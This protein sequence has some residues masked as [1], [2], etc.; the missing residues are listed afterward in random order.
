MQKH[1]KKLS[2]TASGTE[3]E[4][5]L[6]QHY[7]GLGYRVTR[8]QLLSGHQ[9][10]LMASKDVPGAGVVNVM[11]EAK[12]R[13]KGA[14]GINDI[15]NSLNAAQR[16][17]SSHT[18][19][20]AAIIANVAFTAEAQ[21]AVR[22]SA[23]IQLLTLHDLQ[24]QLFNSSESLIRS[25]QDYSI[26][27]VSA[28]YISLA[29]KSSSGKRLADIA[30]HLHYNCAHGGSLLVLLGDFGSGK[31]TILE[32]VFIK[33]AND[34]LHDPSA[35]FP[36]FLRLR[37]LRQHVELWPFIAANLRDY[38]YITPPKQV[39]DSQLE[40]GRLA[41]FL[42]GF[43]EI[44]AG[45]S[46]AD[47]GEFLARLYPLMNSSSPCILSSRPTYFSSPQDML[48]ALSV[49][50]GR[51]RIVDGTPNDTKTRVAL[52]KLRKSMGLGGARHVIANLF[53]D[54]WTI[55][56]LSEEAILAY[57]KQQETTLRSVT[58]KTAIEIR[59]ALGRVYD[60]SDLMRRPLL[61][62]MIVET[63]LNDLIDINKQDM[64]IGPSSL[65][66]AYTQLS[67]DRDSEK[68][69]ERS[70][71]ADARRIVCQFLSLA[72]AK[73]GSAELSDAEVRQ[74]IIDSGIGTGHASP[75]KYPVGIVGRTPNQKPPTESAIEGILTD[76]RSGSFL[77]F[78]REGTLRFA[79]KSY[80]EFFVSQFIYQS[81]LANPNAPTRVGELPLN[82][83]IAYFLG[84]YGRDIPLFGQWIARGTRANSGQ[85]VV[86]RGL[87]LRTMF[88]SGDLLANEQVDDAV[89]QDV[90]LRRATV[91]ATKLKNVTLR[92]VNISDLDAKSWS[93][94]S[95]IIEAC[96]FTS[97]DFAKSDVELEARNSALAGIAF[98]EGSLLLGGKG[99]TLDKSAMSDATVRLA[100]S[101]VLGEVR[102]MRC[103]LHLEMES[104]ASHRFQ[105]S[106]CTIT[107][108]WNADPFTLGDGVTIRK[109][110]ICGLV[111]S[112]DEVLSLYR[113]PSDAP[114]DTG[115]GSAIDGSNEG[116]VFVDFRRA[117]QTAIGKWEG[118]RSALANSFGKLSFFELH[119]YQ[120][121]VRLTAGKRKIA[122]RQLDRT[123][124]KAPLSTLSKRNNLEAVGLALRLSDKIKAR[125]WIENPATSA[126]VAELKA[127][128]FM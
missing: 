102:F 48:K 71:S 121:A 59:Q 95:S 127:S 128:G 122:L 28:E 82:R 50:L 108:N 88:A 124:D 89:I 10:D 25:V 87:A 5:L 109:S 15:S 105:A 74:C 60:L 30:E 1:K 36:I 57:L 32:R 17:L 93:V 81:A 126:I 49:S 51:E 3:F 55:D 112:L 2:T 47:R 21:A 80:M 106:G 98:K 86:S 99:W 111:L 7:E 78:G 120:Q 77:S 20:S 113:P 90:E 53:D 73:S 110:M 39:F 67:F 116:I 24:Q 101:G 117:S 33:C 13:N 62:K 70:L 115:N 100:G 9:I 58:G 8:N 65:Y 6:S 97:V 83:E 104:K 23:N 118:I 61:L 84:S 75:A 103:D 43:D 56:Q 76:I 96:T 68:R 79:H 52:G 16:L 29:A 66:E 18:I 42:D 37:S 40:A 64:A 35:P 92:D 14:I 123:S 38:Q 69:G 119:L 34:R 63:I 26:S 41:I 85:S 12:F 27:K 72:M 125:R 46:V 45:A 19:N 22:A 54:I 107:A 91:T 114:P 94:S 4:L 31:T 11:I 44:Y